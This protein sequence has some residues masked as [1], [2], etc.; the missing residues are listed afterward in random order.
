MLLLKWSKL[1]HA[2]DHKGLT[3]PQIVLQTKLGLLYILTSILMKKWMVLKRC[4][5]AESG[6]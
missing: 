1:I 3:F 5:E 6:T 4:S 2:N